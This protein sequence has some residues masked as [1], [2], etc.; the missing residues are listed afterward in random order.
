MKPNRLVT[1]LTDFGQQDWFAGVMKGVMLAL[2]PDLRIIDIA[3]EVPPGDV[4]SGA[5]S[6]TAA[7]RYFPHGTV[8]VAVVD[9]GVG[10][11]RMAM[12][13]ETSRYFFIAPDNGLLS[14]ALRQEKIVRIHRLENPRYFL[15]DVSRTFHGRDIF[16]PVAAHLS[17][18]V[19]CQRM[20]ARLAGHRRLD[21]PEPRACGAGFR[22][23]IVYVDRF[24]N[25]ITNF[26]NELMD[27]LTAPWRVRF[28]RKT[29]PIAEFY[30]AAPAAQPVAVRGSAGFLEIAVNGGNAARAFGLQV[31][32]PIW[33]NPTR[34]AKS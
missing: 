6:L 15:K 14:F 27:S 32:C 4:R 34:L 23:E 1:L 17:S 33:L 20:G 26:G 13:V 2:Q 8:H 31:G 25:A 7:Y 18:G 16:A 3:H 28:G 24:G 30:H 19:P 9:P 10:G 11:P 22:G 12:V 21:F 5:F 29:C